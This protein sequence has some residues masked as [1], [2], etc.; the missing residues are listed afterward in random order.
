M[1]F[2]LLKPMHFTMGFEL[3]KYNFG[4]L[5]EAMEAQFRPGHFEGVAAVV[6]ELFFSSNT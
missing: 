5:G 2:L 3:N 4:I 1:L 6:K